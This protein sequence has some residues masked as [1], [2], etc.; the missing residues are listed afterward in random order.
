MK[1]LL[2]ESNRSRRLLFK[3]METGLSDLID[4]MVRFCWNRRQ[5]AAAQG[6]D[7]VLLHLSDI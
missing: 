5:L 4:R 1:L 7:E 2:H 3:A 6:F